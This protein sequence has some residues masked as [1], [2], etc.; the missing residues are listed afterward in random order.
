M[1]ID[2]RFVRN[3]HILKLGQIPAFGWN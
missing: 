3:D 2:K 1:L